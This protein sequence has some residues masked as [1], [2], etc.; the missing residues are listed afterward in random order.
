MLVPARLLLDGELVFYLR[1]W[2]AAAVPQMGYQI[3]GAPLYALGIHDAPNIWSWCFGVLLATTSDKVEPWPLLAR[4]GSVRFRKSQ[5][6]RLRCAPQ[7]DDRQVSATAGKLNLQF[8]PRA[9]SSF[10]ERHRI[11]TGRPA[12]PMCPWFEPWLTVHR[13]EAK[14]DF[15]RCSSAERHV[16]AMAIVPCRKIS[17]LA[18]KRSSLEWHQLRWSTEFEFLPRWP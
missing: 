6:W 4:S 1:P 13:A 2:L 12:W 3:A 17:K 9:G 11:R 14:V 16:G 18:Q 8:Q 7:A 15:I 5:S 10:D